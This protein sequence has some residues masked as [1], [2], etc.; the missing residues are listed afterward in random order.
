MCAADVLYTPDTF[1]ALFQSKTRGLIDDVACWL[2]WNE[3]DTG[4]INKNANISVTCVRW[5]L[6]SCM[7]A[8]DSCKEQTQFPLIS[9][10]M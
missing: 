2:L 8:L 1:S 10:E 3:L 4:M 7:H 9:E 5:F 6:A